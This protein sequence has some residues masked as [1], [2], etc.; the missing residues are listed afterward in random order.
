MLF[1]SKPTTTVLSQLTYCWRPQ[2]YR[3]DCDQFYRASFG[4]YRLYSGGGCLICLARIFTV[5]SI[6]LSSSL[7]QLSMAARLTIVVFLARITI[8]RPLQYSGSGLGP[9]STNSYHVASYCFFD[10]KHSSNYNWSR[11]GGGSEGGR[12]GGRD[13]CILQITVLCHKHSQ[14]L[15]HVISSC[16]QASY[17]RSTQ[18]SRNI[19]SATLPACQVQGRVSRDG[20]KIV[21]S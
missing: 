20:D 5:L 9:L 13:S 17:V 7:F 4:I 14:A 12:E 16:H 18:I 21:S 10:K 6:S 1:G 2:F 15:H 19:Q 8:P 3:C 11:L